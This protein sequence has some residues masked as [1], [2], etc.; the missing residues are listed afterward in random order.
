MSASTTDQ[1]ATTLADAKT[2]TK[3]RTKS[4]ATPL[5]SKPRVP[6]ISAAIAIII[7]GAL[8]VAY[9]LTTQG[10]NQTVFA[11]SDGIARG[12]I[13]QTSDLLAVQIPEGEPIPHYLT[14]Q[15]ADVV[16]RTAVVDI[17]A[18]SLVTPN[19]IGDGP[20]I[21]DDRSLVGLS[22]TPA[23]LPS[24]PLTNGD[25]IRVVGTPGNQADVPEELPTPVRATVISSSQ[26]AVTGNTLVSVMVPASDAPRLAAQ[27]STGRVALILDGEQ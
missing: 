13:I 3:T 6:L 11:A 5:Q 2:K 7:L 12:D 27:A 23:Q 9:L 10:Q 14:T 17:P 25:N 15:Q 24:Y 1:S 16:G 26:D 21:P 22:L 19:T 4:L 18:G 8:G 20:G